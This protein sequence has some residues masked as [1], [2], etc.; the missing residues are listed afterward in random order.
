VRIAA[1]EAD[2]SW[3]VCGMALRFAIDRRPQRSRVEGIRDRKDPRTALV[4]QQP[5]PGHTRLGEQATGPN[6][7]L[8]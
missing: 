6:R 7:K 4:V 2:T 1:Q 8:V 3:L 5:K